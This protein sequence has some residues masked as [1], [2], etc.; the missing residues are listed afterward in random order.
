MI[1]KEVE[2]LAVKNGWQ[3]VRHG[4]RHDIYIKN[5]IPLE[6]ERH[7]SREVKIGILIKVLKQINDE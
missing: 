3:F 1:W 4:S 2:R 6:L 7:W 5:G